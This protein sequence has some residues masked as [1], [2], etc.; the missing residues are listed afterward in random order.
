MLPVALRVVATRLAPLTFPAVLMLPPVILP[1]TD[2][3]EPVWLATFTMLVAIILLATTLPVALSVVATMLAP[4]T[5]PAVLM[6]PPWMLAVADMLPDACTPTTTTL[7]VALS[8]VPAITLA[9]VMFPPEP[10]VE[11]LPLVIFPVTDNNPVMYSPEVANTATLPV[12][13]IPIDTLPP[14]LTTVTFDV[15]L[16]MLATDVITPVR[17]APLPRM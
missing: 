2:T 15:P 9:P 11:I 13:P 10:E 17:H 14:E 12:P 16:L 1:D 7:A 8:V 6:L 4:L 3:T 5:L